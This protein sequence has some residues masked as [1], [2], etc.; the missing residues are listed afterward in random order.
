MWT[1]RELKQQAK[2]ALQRNYWKN[3]LVALA[4]MVLSGNWI[5]NVFSSASGVPAEVST[6]VMEESSA[7]EADT[8]VNIGGREH[9]LSILS[10]DEEG[11]PGAVMDRNAAADKITDDTDDTDNTD[12]MYSTYNADDTADI[13]D[14]DDTDDID[15]I[16]D[17]DTTEVMVGFIV[18]FIIMLVIFLIVFLM[19]I[20]IMLIYE[21]LLVFPLMV[22]ADR[23][24]LR[25]LDGR[26]EVKDVAYAFDHSYK[27]VVKTMFHTQLSI[28]LWALLFLIPGIY[29][30]YQYRMVE[31]ILAEHPDLP[32]KDV[33]Q[34]S[35]EMMNGQKWNAFVLDLSFILW[36]FVSVL[37]CGVAYIFYV[38]PYQYLTNAA[39][40][41]RLCAMRDDHSMAEKGARIWNTGF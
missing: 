12:N 27:N 9:S 4:M 31:Y 34:M 33:M 13:G 7:P 21:I 29:K 14:T 39:L 3:V 37:T 16:A 2:D 32:Y 11:D 22:G 10:E 26:A 28:F 35:K 41:R 23:F 19:M 18:G 1:R 24:M 20:A 36:D 38:A 17:T 25:S 30:Q 8:W 40:Y 15:D 6:A 5:G